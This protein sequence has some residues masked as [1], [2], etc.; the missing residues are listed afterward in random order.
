MD[1]HKLSL[2]G[3]PLHYA[4]TGRVFLV[5]P[6]PGGAAAMRAI[7]DEEADRKEGKERAKPPE[8]VARRLALCPPDRA[9]L[10][11][12]NLTV[13][14][15]DLKGNPS[16]GF[17]DEEEEEDVIGIVG[18]SGRKAGKPRWSP[19][20]LLAALPALFKAYKLEFMVAAGWTKDGRLG[21]STLW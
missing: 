11:V 15:D 21:S 17:P 18:G 14:L 5:G 16:I 7:L 9:I 19:D 1:L 20:A 12:T 6:G 4:V 13:L 10:S 8:E 3:F 2:F